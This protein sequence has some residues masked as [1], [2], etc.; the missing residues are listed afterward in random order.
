MIA[1]AEHNIGKYTG[2]ENT[3]ETARAS[4]AMVKVIEKPPTHV[5]ANKTRRR[6]GVSKINT[7]HSPWDRILQNQKEIEEEEQ[8]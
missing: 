8:L 2:S 6:K 7:L 4:Q 5:E 3:F 1:L